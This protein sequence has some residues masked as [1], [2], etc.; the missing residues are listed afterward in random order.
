MKN[1][2]PASASFDATKHLSPADI[3]IGERY[4]Y[5]D[6]LGHHAVR[7]DSISENPSSKGYYR[8]TPLTVEGITNKGMITDVCC[9]A[10]FLHAIVGGAK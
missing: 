9:P 3:K 10:Y 1:K 2:T 5:A 4:V 7:V 8:C 6:D